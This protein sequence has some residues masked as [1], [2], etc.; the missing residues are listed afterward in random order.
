MDGDIREQDTSDRMV[1]EINMEG[2]VTRVNERTCRVLGCAEAEI[3]GKSWFNNFIPDD[4]RK[5]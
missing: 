4:I 5:T 2:Y 1:V 3:V